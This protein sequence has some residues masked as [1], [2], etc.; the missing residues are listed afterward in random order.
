MNNK[1]KLRKINTNR[2]THTEIDEKQN[3]NELYLNVAYEVGEKLDLEKI[4][5]RD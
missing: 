4:L 5:K 1:Q 3:R 2:D